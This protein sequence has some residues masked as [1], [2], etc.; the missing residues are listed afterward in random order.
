MPNSW[1]DIA[2]VLA[3][4]GILACIVGPMLMVAII[5]GG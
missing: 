5:K 4:L 2:G 3:F 1:R